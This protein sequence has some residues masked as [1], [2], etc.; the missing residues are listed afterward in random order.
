MARKFGNEICR[1]IDKAR[2]ERSYEQSR[3]QIEVQIRQAMRRVLLSQQSVRIQMLSR[4]LA[5]NRRA[6]ARSREISLYF[7]CSAGNPRTE[8]GSRQTAATAN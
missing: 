1:A 2:A 3:D 6:G 4:E 7:P 8:T 5:L